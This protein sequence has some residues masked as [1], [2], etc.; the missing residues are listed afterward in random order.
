MSTADPWA[1]VVQ[2]VAPEGQLIRRWPLRGGVSASIHALEIGLPGGQTRRVVVRRHGVADWKPLE[3]DVTAT[4]FA[5]LEALRRAG[6]A[7][8]APCFLD[9]SGEV[10]P[11][12]YL[13]M[14][15]V[16][17]TTAIDEA[18][19]PDALRQMA[20]YLARL[21]AL[22]VGDAEL[23]S[24]PQREDPIAGT[25]EYL[26]ETPLAAR[27]RAA[28]STEAPLVPTN[29]P[30]LLHGDF[31]PENVLWQHG[32]IA[33]VVDWEDAAV[34]DPLS[35]LAS[36]R[37]ELFWK[38]SEQVM[39][40]F[41]AHYLSMATVD[42]TNLPLWELYVSAAAAAYMAHWGLDPEVEA[43]RRRKTSWVLER[44]G[45]RVLSQAV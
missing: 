20:A 34:G 31:W 36:C 8:P 25:L 18:A 14:E 27:L 13:V 19:L 6:M 16:E 32:Q 29:P 11:S 21:H 42:S 26:P 45:Q 9:V 37:V 28:L 40:T 41:T 17:G 33:A 12:P 4:E 44:A 2:R 5:L 30:A 39:E 43:E 1:A 23:P 24:L 15:F 7:V 38:H 10:L 3:A 35:D 22:D